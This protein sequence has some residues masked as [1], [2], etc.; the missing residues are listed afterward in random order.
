VGLEG[1][2]QNGQ[3]GEVLASHGVDAKTLSS[4]LEGVGTAWL[5]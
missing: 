3:P 5:A 2:P 4:V 1:I